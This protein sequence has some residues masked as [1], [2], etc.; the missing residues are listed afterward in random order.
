MSATHRS[1]HPASARKFSAALGASSPK[2]STTMRPAGAPPMETSRKQRDVASGGALRMSTV[3]AVVSVST[4]RPSAPTLSA[5]AAQAGRKPAASVAAAPDA[6]ALRRFSGTVGRSAAHAVTIGNTPRDIELCVIGG[7]P[8]ACPGTRA[9]IG[10][11]RRRPELRCR[12]LLSRREARQVP[13][14][15]PCREQLPDL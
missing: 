4:S 1:R 11:D 7:S 8:S 13:G 3:A 2:R 5:C 15:C 6:I 9:G 12:S 10:H 14:S